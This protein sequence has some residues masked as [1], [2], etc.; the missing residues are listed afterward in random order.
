MK[1]YVHELG[2]GRILLVFCLQHYSLP[3]CTQESFFFVLLI[4]FLNS[5]PLKVCILNPRSVFPFFFV[6]WSAPCDY[7]M[8]RTIAKFR[9]PD[10]GNI[11]DSGIGLSYRPAILG[12]LAGRY[13]NTM[14][15]LN[16]SPHS[17][18]LWIWLQ[19]PISNLIYQM[20]QHLMR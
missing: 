11:V 19:N 8:K 18:G 5:F 14:P 15:E 1:L 6:L 16:L 13:D 9:V 20:S 3:W 4:S 10:W 12:S 17:Q 7:Y 2:F